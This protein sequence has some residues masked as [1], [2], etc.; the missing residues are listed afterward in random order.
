MAGHEGK[1]L[2][3]TLLTAI[4]SGASIFANSYAVQGFDPFG[5]AT[6]KNIL[7]AVALVAALLFAG[8]L[9]EVSS[10][11]RRNLLWLAAIGVIGGSIPFLLFF[12]GLKLSVAT[13]ASFIHKT[14][15][16]FAALGAVAFLRE[17]V[18]KIAIAGGIGVLAGTFILIG[19]AFSFGLGEFLV[20]AATLM[21]SAEQV[22]SKKVLAEVSPRLVATG[23][24]LFGSVVLLAFMALTGGLEKTFVLDATHWQWALLSAGFLL[25]YVSAWY[26]GL[27]NTSVSKATAVLTLGAP[28]TLALSFAFAGKPLLL[29]QAAGMLLMVAGVAAVVGSD[30]ISKALSFTTGLLKKPQPLA[31]AETKD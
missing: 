10:L 4:I 21:W 7:V 16:V 28:I 3:F 24:M 12:W 18:T 2:V 27:K 20:L 19:P 8:Q 22:V 23:R 31:I 11:S 15:F 25:L 5:F 30:S 26:V 1:G 14:L 17:K 29:E 13:S 9:L 6:L